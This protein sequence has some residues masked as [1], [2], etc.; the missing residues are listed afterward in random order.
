ML[1]IYFK[2]SIP[3]P[4]SSQ[5]IW[6]LYFSLDLVMSL[7]YNQGKQEAAQSCVSRSHQAIY[8]PW[9]MFSSLAVTISLSRDELFLSPVSTKL[10]IMNVH[11]REWL[12]T[13]QWVIQERAKQMKKMFCKAQA[14]IWVSYTS[15]GLLFQYSFKSSVPLL[16][17]FT[18]MQTDF[19]SWAL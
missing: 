4:Q 18:V 11:S 2:M 10:W 3:L 16:R 1:I 12:N 9:D 13:S 14:P 5:I 15:I 6:K 17:S 19:V 7:E 8:W